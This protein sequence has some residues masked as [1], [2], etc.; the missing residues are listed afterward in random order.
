M[1]F[2]QLYQKYRKIYS[3]LVII[4]KF[5]SNFMN[6]YIIWLYVERMKKDCL[7]QNIDSIFE[8]LTFWVDKNSNE[9]ADIGSILFWRRFSVNKRSNESIKS[10]LT[11]TLRHYWVEE[12]RTWKVE[13]PE[14]IPSQIDLNMF[15]Q[16]PITFYGYLTSV[17][18]DFT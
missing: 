9:Y 8:V 16:F 5:N 1:F 18:I 2:F 12:G 7:A 3:F 14:K 6:G 4:R 17:D 11:P 15:T 13:W 10:K